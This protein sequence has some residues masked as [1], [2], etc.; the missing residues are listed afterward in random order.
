ME[1]LLIYEV[2]YAVL[3]CRISIHV[4]FPCLSASE[5]STELPSMS[6]RD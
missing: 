1:I 5:G 3:P 4:Y 2:L 6:P